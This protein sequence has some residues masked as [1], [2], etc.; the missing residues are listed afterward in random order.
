MTP[1]DH[2]T[3]LA[4]FIRGVELSGG[5][6]P[7][8][9]MTVTS[10]DRLDDPLEKLWF[11]GCYALT[12]NWPTAERIWLEW[13]PGEFEQGAFLRWAEDNWAGIGLRKERKAVFRKP[14]FAES[15]ASYLAFSRD[16]LSR[17]SLP[18]SYADA[19]L[20]FNGGCRYMGRY[21]A[22]RWLEVMRRAFGTSWTMT[23]VRSDG[24]EHPRKAL[25]LI[26]PGDAAALLGGNSRREVAIADRCADACLLDLHTEFGITT[27]YYQLQSLLCEYK[28]SVLGQK[29]YPGKSID[30]EMGYFDKIYAYWGDAARV[31]SDFYSV[32]EEC[33]PSWSLGE[34]QGWLGVR[35]ELGRVLVA[36]GYTWSDAVYDYAASAADLAAPV[37]RADGAGSLL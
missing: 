24:G 10:M 13:R 31:D 4:E 16:L 35:P 25:A 12:Y 36:H 21:I 11:A 22:I 6:T 17:D 15:A 33:F 19:F 34:Q 29:Q 30:T 8:V 28:Q 26:Y 18:A 23:D 37:K 27:D 3:H 32:R 14:F 9:S 5:T 7:H 20:A 2:L 1:D